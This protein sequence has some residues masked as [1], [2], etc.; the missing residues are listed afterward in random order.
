MP[1]TPEEGANRRNIK[2]AQKQI[3]EQYDKVISEIFQG[4]TNLKF[5]NETFRLSDNPR[6]KELVERLMKDFRVTVSAILVNAISDGF[7]ISKAN[8]IN[9]VYSSL[10]GRSIIPEV[11]QILNATYEKQ[12][13]AFLNRT[14]DGLKLSDRVWNL[15]RQLQ[16]EIEWTVFSGL[17]EG[18]SAQDMAKE[19]RRFLNNPDKLFRRVRNSQGKLVLSKAAKE[20]NPGQ[21]VYRSSYKN[22]MRLSRTEINTAYRTSD[23]EQYK[24][25]PFVLGV[26]IRLSDAHPVFDM[27]DLLV[28][29]YPSW[30]K[31]TGWHI[32]CICYTVPILPSREEFMAYQNALLR[33]EEYTFKNRVNEI[34]KKAFDWVNDNKARIKKWKT[35]PVFMLDNR[36]V[37]KIE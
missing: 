36:D 3:R 27:C 21:G 25:T 11:K 13:N 34:P 37:F 10:D 19:L 32:Q 30:F 6:F 18:Q 9:T 31:F 17:S 26:E 7:N 14:I 2:K 35:P 1:I 16:R 15:S 23:H 29:V 8:F 24:N 28:G 12:L 22:A 4:A 33:G 20:F 5:A